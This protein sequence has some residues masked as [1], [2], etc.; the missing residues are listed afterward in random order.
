MIAQF[1]RRRNPDTSIDSICTRCVQTIAS[2]ACE[3]EL[4]TREQKHICD[5]N[6]EFSFAFFNSEMRPRVVRRP[7]V[8]RR[9]S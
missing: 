1:V 3:A 5:P 6:G 7:Q 8:N 4:A 9:E 2:A